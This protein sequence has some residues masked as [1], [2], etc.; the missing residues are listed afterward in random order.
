MIPTG[1]SIYIQGYWPNPLGPC[2]DQCDR[3]RAGE[4]Q[5]PLH[6]AFLALGP[7]WYQQRRPLAPFPTFIGGNPHNGLVATSIRASTLWRIASM[8]PLSEVLDVVGPSLPPAVNNADPRPV[9]PVAEYEND[10]PAT[11]AARQFTKDSCNNSS[12]IGR[13][14][15]T[16]AAVAII[17]N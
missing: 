12:R 13:K 4:Y 15:A 8:E 1:L 10:W 17:S 6:N 14:A 2:I 3:G 11:S 7:S 16:H 5:W 9:P